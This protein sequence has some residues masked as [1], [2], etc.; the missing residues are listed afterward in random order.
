M[1][2]DEALRRLL[3]GTGLTY[4]VLGGT[5]I[6]LQ[7]VGQAPADPSVLQLDPVQ[8][9]GVF[10][11]PSQA[12]IDN[13]PPP[14]AGGQVATGGQIGSARQPRRHG[15]AVQPDELHRPEGAGPAGAD[16]SRRADRRSVGTHRP[17]DRQQRRAEH[18][19]P[20][21][22]RR[23]HGYRLW[24][25]LRPAADLFDRC[26]TRRTHRGAEGTERDAERH[27][28]QRRDRRHDQRGAQARPRR[29][30][31]P[32]DAGL[33]LGRAVRRRRRCRP[34]L[35][36]GKRSGR[37]HQ[38]RLSRRADGCAVERRGAGAGV[39]RRRLSRRRLPA[40]ARWRLPVPVH[41]RRRRLCQRG[42]GRAGAGRAGPQQQLHP[43]L[44]LHHRPGPLRRAAR[45][46]RCLAGRDA[47]RR[48]RRPR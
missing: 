24:R 30:D 13:I 37:A 47:L 44:E 1:S 26:R 46:S 5:T 48:H 3:A 7:R 33:Q 19:D 4:S 35:R 42:G 18:D 21:L 9:Q 22:H 28:A 45:R 17:A 16:H 8:V 20:R 12:M 23:K 2:V 25:A 32:G 39:D 36:S 38:R 34:P 29:A 41:Q 11:V 40:L 14:Y 6:A 10:P 43:A 15:H 27:G 31:E